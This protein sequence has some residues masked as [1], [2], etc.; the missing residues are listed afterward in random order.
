MS[1][2]LLECKT[3]ALFNAFVGDRSRFTERLNREIDAQTSA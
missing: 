3:A 1:F 2:E